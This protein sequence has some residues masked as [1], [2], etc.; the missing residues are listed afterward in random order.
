MSTQTIANN[1]SYYLAQKPKLLKDHAAIL[2]VGRKLMVARYGLE[3]TDKVEREA[4]E[5]FE[6][7]IPEIPYI[8]G[9]DNSLTD[10]ITQMTSMLALYRVLKREGKTVEDIGELIY[11]MA[12]AWTEQYPAFMRAL[13]GRV[14]MTRFWQ[15]RT[16]RKAATSQ[17]L[18][19]P[20]NFVFEYVPGDG[21]EFDWGINY[22]ECGV[23]KFFH[24]QDAD[25]L[26]PYMCLLDYVMF[27]ALG[28][29]L[30]RTGTIAHG[31]THCDFRFKKGGETEEGWPP[32]FWQNA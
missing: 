23:V 26:A 9:K 24:R 13:I 4:R 25:E 1:A 29:G 10:T 18:D 11:R 8:G 6:R 28:L 21:Q 32:K 17:G 15:N 27:Q 22:T 12:K 19:Y 31:C 20:E 3:F 2:A 5:E 7:L 14:Y 30:K 16:S